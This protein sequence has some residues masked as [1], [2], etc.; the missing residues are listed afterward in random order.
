MARL[1][2]HHLPLALALALA[3]G[4][5]AAQAVEVSA[6]GFATLG[7]AQSDSPYRYQRFISDDGG[8]E[9]DTL[10]AGQLDLRF[11]PAWSAT[12]QV[13]LA[14]DTDSD[15]H[16]R[17]QPTW[18][19]VGWRPNDDWLLRAGKMRVPLYLYS[20]SLDVGAT[21]VLARLPHEVYSIAPANEFVG[22]YASRYVTFGKQEWSLDAYGGQTGIYNRAWS[23]DGLPP[24]RSAGATF[25]EFEVKVVG[26]VAT[27]RGEDSTYRVGL[28]ATDT[29]RT[30][31]QPFAVRF[32]RVDLGPGLSYYRVAQ[33]LPG[34][35]LQTTD[36]VGNVVFTAGA[37]RSLGHGWRLWGEY[38]RVSQRGTDLGS[39]SHAGYL[40]A[41]RSVGAF[42]PYA[43]LGYQRS[44]SSILDTYDQLTNNPLPGAVPGAALINAAQRVAAESLY[45]FDQRSVA[46]GVSY[47]LSATSKLNLEALQTRVGR[48]STHFNAP[49]GE[50]DPRRLR[51]NTW[52]LNYSVA[53]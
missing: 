16:W 41:S 51:V 47:A 30:D 3:M 43:V 13:K 45:A 35:P 46:L 32:P 1:K 12:L 5:G 15:S 29:R 48:I 53:F 26:A 34:P 44:D 27:L 7:W 9:R 14:A 37:E 6:S 22:A 21:Q 10:L 39:D 17:L 11:T 50:P 20:E 8:F 33:A 28:H 18:A 38:V 23:R 49:P 42:T 2:L 25:D 52:L 24:A 19:F 31:G 36:S 40:A 4:A